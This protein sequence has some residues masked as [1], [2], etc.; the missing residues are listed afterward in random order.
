MMGF[1][2][3]LYGGCNSEDNPIGHMVVL[4][5]LS[6]SISVVLL[7]LV[8]SYASLL[9]SYFPSL[10]VSLSFLLFYFSTFSLFYFTPSTK[11]P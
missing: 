7:W 9:V 4:M 6:L 1:R 3:P 10:F 5:T 11:I 8:Q 2:L